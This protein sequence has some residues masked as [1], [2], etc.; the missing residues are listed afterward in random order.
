MRKAY[1]L[2]KLSVKRRGVGQL[3][4]GIRELK[5]EL[6]NDMVFLKSIGEESE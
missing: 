2:K 6:L 4:N 1:D 3:L 5:S